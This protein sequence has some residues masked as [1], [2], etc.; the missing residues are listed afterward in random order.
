MKDYLL[1]ECSLNLEDEPE[2]LSN[3]YNFGKIQRADT[4]EKHVI[5]LTTLNFVVRREKLI[6]SKT[7][8]R[9]F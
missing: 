1:P 6:I 3:A 8:G 2:M 7:P 4:E 5:L 9:Y